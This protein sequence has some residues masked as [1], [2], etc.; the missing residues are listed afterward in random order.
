MNKPAWK[1]GLISGTIILVYS[2]IALYL[3]G[4]PSLAGQA[5]FGL[6]QSL[7]YL[8][9][10]ILLVFLY[11]AMRSFRSHAQEAPSFRALMRTGV[12]VTLVAA[13][14][15]GLL[16]GVY[17]ALNPGFYDHYMMAYI[18]QLKTSGAPESEIRQL[19]ESMK[20]AGFMKTPLA[21]GLYYFLEMAFVG[22]I[23]S[24]A[25]AMVMRK[26]EAG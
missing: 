10:L 23:A 5:Q 16:E 21:N 6:F 20:Q 13:L 22:N 18:G 4:D 1:Y 3:L 19:E 15:A 12:L 17:L 11:L 7:G 9:Y 25:F 26:R 2:A 8:R 24:L 14:M